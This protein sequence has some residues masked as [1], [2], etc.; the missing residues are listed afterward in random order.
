MGEMHKIVCQ[1]QWYIDG[2][3]RHKNSTSKLLFIFVKGELSEGKL[4]EV[5]LNKFIY[6]SC[7]I[8]QNVIEFRYNNEPSQ[9][10][11]R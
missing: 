5:H 3:I 8:N 4:I 1:S 6:V 11:T 9:G 2:E 10:K 7:T